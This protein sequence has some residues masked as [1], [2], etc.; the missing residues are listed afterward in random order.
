M[1]AML[2]NFISVAIRNILGNKVF[3]LI[4]VTGLATGL[5]AAMLILLWIQDELSYDRFHENADNIY[6]VEEDQF[7]SG[8]IYHVNV[9]PHPSGPVWRERIPEIRD[10]TRINRMPRILVRNNDMAF[11]E[12]NVCLLY[13]SPSPRDRQKS[14]MP[15]SA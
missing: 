2:K 9:T 12:S 14:R 6:R 8:R 3:T 7:Y 15:S 10:Q 5:A 11:Y 1:N 4:N 13:T